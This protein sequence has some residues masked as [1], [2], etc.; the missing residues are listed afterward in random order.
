ML[1]APKGRFLFNPCTILL[2][3]ILKCE[4]LCGICHKK[5]T[6]KDSIFN[7]IKIGRASCRERVFVHV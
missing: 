4:V 2:N 3:E 7:K 5:H 6:I 1:L